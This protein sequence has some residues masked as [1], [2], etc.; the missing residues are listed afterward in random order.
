MNVRAEGIA[1]G[2]RSVAANDVTLRAANLPMQ[3]FGFFNTSRAYG[4]VANPAGS[5]GDLCIGGA[6]IGRYVGPG[7]IQSSGSGNLVNLSIDVNQ[8]PQPNGFVSAM[9]GD[10][11]FFQF[12]YR[13][14]SPNGPTSNFNA[15]IRIRCEGEAPDQV[16]HRCPRRDRSRREHPGVPTRPPETGSRRTFRAVLR[17]AA[18]LKTPR[19]GSGPGTLGSASRWY[20]CRAAGPTRVPGGIQDGTNEPLFTG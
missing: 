1:Y 17:S 4:F 16:E 9:P 6:P 14:S 13:D 18:P 5:S 7:Q 10:A 19:R 12:W 20:Q 3:S 11:W 2:S 8:I 15:A